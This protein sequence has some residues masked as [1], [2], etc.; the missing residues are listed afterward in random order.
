MQGSENSRPPF[1]MAWTLWRRRKWMAIVVFAMAFSTAASLVLA[2]P[3]LYRA[4]A[5]VLVEQEQVPE[6]FVRSSVSDELKPRLQVVNQQI[7]SRAR[8]QEMIARF[9]LYPDLRK[10]SSEAAIERMRRDIQLEIKE[11]EQRRG[12]T[13]T[14][15]FELTYQG[16]D[17]QI[18]AQVTNTLGSHYVREN[19][20]IRERQATRTTGFL[21]AQFTGV[22]KQL[23]EQEKRISEF[24]NR[25][26]G[27]LPEQQVANLAMLERF[28]TQLRM[29]SD[30]QLRAMNH[31]ERL[32]EEGARAGM[33][34]PGHSPEGMTVRL[35]QLRRRLAELR[36]RYTDKYPDVIHVKSEIA[37]LERQQGESDANG[38]RL[39]M[40][41]VSPPMLGKN[42]E[43][44]ETDLQSLKKEEAE[45]RGNIIKYQSRVENTPRLEQE[46]RNL[47]RD[48]D[49]TREVYASLLQRYEDAQLAEMLVRQKGEQFRV[50]N[51]A[52]PP[53][54]SAG[55]NRLRLL[56]MGLVLSFGLAAGAV[57]LAEQT[58]TSFHRADDL[59][60]FT[61]VPVL[62]SI[63]RIITKRD[64]WR[65]RLRF[66]AAILL[67]GI[68]LFILVRAAYFFAQDNHQ[69]VWMLTQRGA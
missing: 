30:N 66:S 9:D 18:V 64:I 49:A 21:K 2:L 69:L 26:L 41:S 40:A 50:L 16:W 29:N 7:L 65:H 28:Y 5:T 55:P 48:Y 51:L 43:K 63:P 24:K 44:I 17:P 45:L 62:V 32:L 22:Q 3:N 8:L 13:A 56:L 35:I 52:I 15:A 61:K 68:G 31:R 38:E 36:T 20:Q 47:T 58:D 60:S 14:V 67:L 1:E 4:T 23:R 59:R 57:F 27:D 10:I 33:L 6:T 54:A 37:A 34:P 11:V 25:H 39:Q 53:K 42:F 46:L 12:G 19:E